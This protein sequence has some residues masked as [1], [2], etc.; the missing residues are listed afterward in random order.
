MRALLAA[1]LALILAAPAKAQSGATIGLPPEVATAVAAFIPEHFTI[2]S[3]PAEV[4]LH[5]N[6]NL[7]TG[8]A[9][10]VFRL[11]AESAGDA[12]EAAFEVDAQRYYVAFCRW[13]AAPDTSANAM[14]RQRDFALSRLEAEEI[15]W[16]FLSAL[17]P[18]RCG[19]LRLISAGDPL[20]P[21]AGSVPA[22]AF[23]W[24]GRT[25]DAETGDGVAI[26]VSANAGEILRFRGRPALDYSWAD[27]VV[28]REQAIAVVREFLRG[29]DAVDLGDVSFETR[30]VL[31][32]PQTPGEGP[33]WHVIA[34]RPPKTEGDEWTRRLSRVVDARTGDLIKPSPA[35]DDISMGFFDRPAVLA[36]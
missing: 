23:R 17:W 11:S 16:A 25:G 20:P 10:Y 28:E 12:W 3:D 32:H 35:L 4:Q 15:A 30:M 19:S 36:P 31:S 26:Q 27:V 22:F 7:I 21:T 24:E 5:A 6:V 29:T 33:A 14:L 2:T 18:R 8:R 34:I 1:G 9:Q 13:T